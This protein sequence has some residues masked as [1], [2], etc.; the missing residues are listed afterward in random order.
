MRELAE[1]GFAYAEISCEMAVDPA[2]NWFSR[3]WMERL[4][5]AAR[6]SGLETPQVHYPITTLTTAAAPGGGWDP[7]R[8]A[9]LAH[10]S[11][12]RRDREMR[13]VQDLLAACPVAGI[14]IVV[15]HP[16]GSRGVAGDAEHRRVRE[17]N[18]EAFASLAPIA[19]SYGVTLALENMGR[20]DGTPQFGCRISELCD[21]IEAVA[22]PNIGV[23]LDTSHAFIMAQDIPAAI[24]RL[25]D[26]LVATHLSD[27]LGTSDDHLMPG[28]GGI[29]WHR[30]LSA[31]GS[32]QYGGL[33]NLEIPGE[34][35]CPIDT[36]RLKA[37]HAR[38]L[39]EAMRG[40][41]VELPKFR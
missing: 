29:E 36:L 9:D 14:R 33:L 37:R 20:V 25:G 2:A 13:C 32:I 16:G 41:S 38:R 3:A 24:T 35:D 19:A 15:I 6:A 8:E 5:R 7:E 40:G 23:C 21:L 10:P 18:R 26:R 27:S 22:A 28:S 4:R 12:S 1:A 17:L 30:V 31:L 11:R 34:T 39:L